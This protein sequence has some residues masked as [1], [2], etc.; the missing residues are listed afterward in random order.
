MPFL[1]QP[2]K[3]GVQTPARRTAGAAG[4][5][6]SFP[7]AVVLAPHSRNKL[8][9]GWT[10]EQMPSQC[11]LQFVLRSSWTSRG[12]RL[13]GGV[14]DEDY[15]GH[16]VYANLAND[17]DHEVEIAA[18]HAV[19][20]AI[21]MR[22]VDEECFAMPLTGPPADPKKPAEFTDQMKSIYQ[23]PST[24][25]PAEG[26]VPPQPVNGAEDSRD[27]SAALYRA[28]CEGPELPSRAFTGGRRRFGGCPNLRGKMLE[29]FAGEK[30]KFEDALAAGSCSEEKRPRRDSL[31]ADAPAALEPGKEFSAKI[32]AMTWTKYE[33]ELAL[34]EERGEK[35]L[36]P[37]RKSGYGSTGP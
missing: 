28:H 18:G 17:N 15:L 24:A 37:Q 4:Y 34:P 23:P 6:V 32:A 25:E 30:K 29:R 31:D 20:Q 26:F 33:V 7:E 35:S 10:I 8:P 9:L 22:Y 13:E 3:Q 5:D 36:L 1:I 16:E 2:L 11:Y 19:F 12:I 27:F 21:C 14:I